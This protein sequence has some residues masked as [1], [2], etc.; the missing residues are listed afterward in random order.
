MLLAVLVISNDGTP[1][2]TIGSK[3]I[4]IDSAVISGAVSV[5]KEMI[6]TFTGIRKD[7]LSLSDGLNN[8]TMFEIKNKNFIVVFVTKNQ[9]PIDKIK[10]YHIKRLLEVHDLN[11]ALIEKIVK[12]AAKRSKEYRFL[13]WGDMW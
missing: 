6:T 7:H 2:A 1:L 4:N 12:F 9:D 13:S 3:D 5:A 11:E 10:I 8:I